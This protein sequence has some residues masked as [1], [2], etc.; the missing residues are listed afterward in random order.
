M[1]FERG[2]ELSARHANGFHAGTWDYIHVA[3][4]QL[5][6]VETFITCDVAQADLARASG[7][8]KVHLFE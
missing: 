4:A 7:L 5:S 6:R 2:D 3:A 1:L 8:L